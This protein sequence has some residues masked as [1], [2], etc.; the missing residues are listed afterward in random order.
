M[1]KNKIN[2]RNFLKKASIPVI[3]AASFNTFNVHAS[4][5]TELNMVNPGCGINPYNSPNTF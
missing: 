4:S 3:G 2:R 5:I 1:K